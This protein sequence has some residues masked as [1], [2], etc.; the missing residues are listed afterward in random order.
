MFAETVNWNLKRAEKSMTCEPQ[1]SCVRQCATEPGR[2]R[3]L[4]LGS[5]YH[6]R[7]RSHQSHGT[8]YEPY[9]SPDEA[10]LRAFLDTVGIT[11]E[12]IMQRCVALQHQYPQTLVLVF[13][14]APVHAC[15]PVRHRH[16]AVTL[17]SLSAAAGKGH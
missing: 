12:A 17:E 7:D 6:T 3:T 10:P 13:S 8:D 15:F 14:D 16:S 4:R 5:P 1:P 9:L 2:L 11:K